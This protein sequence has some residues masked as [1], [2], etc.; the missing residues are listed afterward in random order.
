MRSS[1]WLILAI[2]LSVAACNGYGMV[3]SDEERCLQSG[4]RWI[5]ALEQCDI[6]ASGGAGGNGGGGGGGM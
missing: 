1:R 2:W 5:A 4:G 3:R 6:Q